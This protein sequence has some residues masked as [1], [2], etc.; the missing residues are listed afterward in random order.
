MVSRH[1]LHKNFRRRTQIINHALGTIRFPSLTCFSS[2]P[3]E[4]VT[5]VDPMLFRDEILQIELDLF[6]IILLRETNPLRKPTH[7]SIND[8]TGWNSERTSENAIRRLSSD[9]WKLY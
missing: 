7:M 1:R 9:A 6:G 3:D 8:D 4:H 5:E 2:M